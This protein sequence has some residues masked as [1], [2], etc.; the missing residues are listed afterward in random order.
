MTWLF[1]GSH[2]QLLVT[3]VLFGFDVK[4]LPRFICFVTYSEILFHMEHALGA[5]EVENNIVYG[6]KKWRILTK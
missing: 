2:H 6:S 4:L 3:V 1:S 5:P